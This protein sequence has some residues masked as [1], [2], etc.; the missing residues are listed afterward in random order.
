M[1]KTGPKCTDETQ[2]FSCTEVTVIQIKQNEGQEVGK[3]G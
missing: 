3:K 2:G 1:L